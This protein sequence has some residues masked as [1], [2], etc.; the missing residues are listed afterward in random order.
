MKSAPSI[1]VQIVHIEGPLK[2]QIQ[3]FAESEISIGRHPSCGIRFPADLN[4][5][6][7]RHARITREGNRFK[8]NDDSTNG[9]VL[10]GELVKE[11][12]LKDGDVLAIAQGGPKISFLTRQ[13]DLLT[14]PPSPRQAPKPVAAPTAPAAAHEAQGVPLQTQEVTPSAPLASTDSISREIR[15]KVP[16]VIQ[17]GPTLRS[18]DELPVSMGKAPNCDFSVEGPGM[19]SQHALVFY[20]NGSYQVKDLTGQELVRINSKPAGSGSTLAPDDQ[21]SLGQQGPCFR[22]LGG[23]RLIEVETPVETPRGGASSEQIASEAKTVGTL[24]KKTTSLLDKLFSRK[25]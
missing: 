14:E 16:L 12:Y 11:A 20:A 4:L 5:V 24:N 1:I 18:F 10:N 23:G 7:R 19:Q 25:R 22:F 8:L 21:L 15:V 2:G 13:G 3:E 6:S 17:Y 9:T